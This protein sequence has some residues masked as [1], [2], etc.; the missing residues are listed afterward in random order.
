MKTNNMRT[1]IHFV[2]YIIIALLIAGT[3]SK[4]LADSSDIK[5]IVHVFSVDHMHLGEAMITLKVQGLPTSGTQLIVRRTTDSST[6]LSKTT[7][8]DGKMESIVIMDHI[9]VEERTSYSVLL[10]GKDGKE[11]HIK[12]VSLSTKET[13]SETQS[14]VGKSPI[15][16]PHYALELGRDLF[17]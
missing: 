15:T 13:M 14:A 16:D 11:K 8:E 4:T 7:L 9:D 1:L 2:K 10:V 3:T 17:E 5:S 6:I 12:T